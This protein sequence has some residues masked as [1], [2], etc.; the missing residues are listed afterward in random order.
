MSFI[1]DAAANGTKLKLLTV[2]KDGNRAR[3]RL[4]FTVTA[5]G[6][7]HAQSPGTGNMRMRIKLGIGIFA[8]L[9]LTHA[10]KPGNSTFRACAFTQI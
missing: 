9:L 8:P 10:H 3:G 5:E 4:P 6:L 7:A 1:I 2:L